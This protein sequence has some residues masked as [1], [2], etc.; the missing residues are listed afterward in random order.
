MAGFDYLQAII[1]GL[2]ANLAVLD[3]KG[4]I[5]AVNAAWMRF[6]KQNN[7]PEP[8]SGAGANY[9]DMCL[10][11]LRQGGSVPKSALE[12]VAED[13]YGARAG[14]GVLQ[15]LSGERGKFQLTYPCHGPGER[16]WYLLTVTPLA[17]DN[18]T[19]AMVAHENVTTLKQKEESVTEALIGTVEAISNIGEVRDP[20]TAG[21]QNHV[22][23]LAVRIASALGLPADARR[24]VY[25]GAQIH[26]I[27]KIGIP[28][29]ILTRPG[30]LNE[31]EMRLVRCH[32]RIGYDL[33][34]GIPFPWPIAQIVLQHH[35]RMDGSGYPDGLSGN[36][37]LME[38]RIVMVADVVDAMASHR[39]YR[40]GKGLG[41]ANEEIRRMAGRHYDPDVVDAYLSESVQAYAQ[42]VYPH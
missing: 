12:K 25:L 4:E 37:I 1:D 39:P 14:Y 9:I 27:G 32:S 23:Q 33:I 21:H 31:L 7:N 29:E 28:A 16:R 17:L 20:Y 10:P 30:P 15:V 8:S 13:D 41:L 19:Y 24:A 40:P 26:D 38:S 5:V 6:A 2:S 3:R 35:E 22:A 36:Q 11:G 42:A 34:A 18:C